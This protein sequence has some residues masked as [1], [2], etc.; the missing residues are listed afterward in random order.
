MR[1]CG[2]QSGRMTALLWSGRRARGTDCPQIEASPC[3]NCFS[4]F[5][6]SLCSPADA[7]SLP[8]PAPS[9]CSSPMSGSSASIPDYVTVPV[10]ISGGRD[11][12]LR[13]W[14]GLTVRACAP[15]AVRH[16]TPPSPPTL[17]SPSPPVC[18]QRP[19]RSSLSPY[20]AER[21]SPQHRGVFIS[22]F[23][24]AL[25]GGSSRSFSCLPSLHRYNLF[26]C[27]ASRS[28]RAATSPLS[29][30]RSRHPA[31]GSARLSL[32]ASTAAPPP[33][34][35][36]PRPT[37][38]RPR[39]ALPW[40]QSRLEPRCRLSHLACPHVVRLSPRHRRLHQPRLSLRRHRLA[41]QG[42]VRRLPRPLPHQLSCVHLATSRRQQAGATLRGC[43]RWL[44]TPLL[45]RTVTVNRPQ[46]HM[47]VGAA[48]EYAG[49]AM[50]QHSAR[51]RLSRIPPTTTAAVQT[52]KP[53]CKPLRFRRPRCRRRRRPLRMRGPRSRLRL[54]PTPAHHCLP[55]R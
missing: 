34:L 32:P 25:A 40:P 35:R 36:A 12:V 6:P 41:R 16:L 30:C 47:A 7:A 52:H 10:V 43:L 4:P 17:P 28:V 53:T 15:P 46:R 14:V 27:L 20:E 33:P 23:G 26:A 11:R 24:C 2:W 21:V 1:F 13:C 45:W 19:D 50:R 49:A 18:P 42:L 3:T 38:P 9:P 37:P 55:R 22:A 48:L 54:R 39:A 44:G 29:H 51:H 8:V 31:P 5:P